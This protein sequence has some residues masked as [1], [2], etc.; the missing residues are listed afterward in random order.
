MKRLLLFLSLI[1]CAVTQMYALEEVTVNGVKRTLIAY[2]P[3]NLPRQAPLIIACHGMNQ[4]APYLQEKSQFE[5]VADTAGFVIVYANGLNKSWDI[6]GTSD[7]K[8]ME[9]II[10][11]MYKRYGINKQRVYLTGFSMGGMFTYHCANMLSDKIAA[12]CPVS[13][14]PMGGPSAHASRPVPILHTHGTADDVCS[15]SPVQSHINAWVNFNGCDKTPVVVKPYPASNPYSPAKRE[16]YLNGRNGVEVS[17]ITLDNKGHW[18]SMDE[19][20]AITSIEVWNFCRQYSLGDAEPEVE[21]I[22]PENNSFDLRSDADTEFMLQ[23]TDTAVLTNL[24][25]QL[26]A[27]DG[28]AIDLKRVGQDLEPFIKLVI[29][30]GTVV[31][32]GTYTLTLEGAKSKGGTAMRRQSFT[33]AYGVEEVGETLNVDTLFHP[34]FYASQETIGEGIPEGWRRFTVNSEGT[35]EMTN[36]GTANCAGVRLKYFQRGGDFDAG[37]YL[38]ARDYSSCRLSYGMYRAYRLSLTK[39]KYVLSFNSTY[40]SEGSKNANATYNVYLADLVSS[41]QVWAES[42]LNSTN[43]MMESTAQTITGSKHYELDMPVNKDGLYVLNFEMTEGWNSVIVGNMTLTTMPSLA[44]RYKGTFLRTL[45]AA[46]SRMEQYEGSAVTALQQVV[47]KYASLVSTSPSVYTK[48]T[49]ALLAAIRTFD[50]SPNK[51]SGLDAPSACIEDHDNGYNL[52]GQPAKPSQ[53]GLWIS[54]DHRITY[55]RN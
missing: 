27:D 3:K 26:V 45:A 29:P 5:S 15:Y 44:D 10:D 12:F 21:S 42:S 50:A 8:F 13:G 18:W 49:E 28:S 54:P 17:L 55:R 37:F 11:L 19:A 1:V 6:S 39:G 30:S 16:R 33:Y 22:V 41:E 43:T 24:K 32:N 14:Y 52:Q 20:Q 51:V 25:A 2:A 47:D 53:P 40:W 34:D 9:Y 48:A 38:S 7:T 46:R 23:L 35:S 36:G 31:P 4:D